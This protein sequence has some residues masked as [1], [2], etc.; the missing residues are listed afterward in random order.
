[1][2]L[3]YG[4]NAEIPQ[5]KLTEYLLSPTHRDGRHEAAF[6]TRFGFSMAAWQ[7]LAAT[8]RQHALDHEVTKE[9]DAPFGKRYV[10]EGIMQAPDGRAPMLR[11]VWFIERGSGTPR[12]VTAYPL[13]R[14]SDD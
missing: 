4:Q 1:M 3:P 14:T 6:F 2:R 13:R 9:E 11:A 7:D 10:I 8:L 12:F 5:A